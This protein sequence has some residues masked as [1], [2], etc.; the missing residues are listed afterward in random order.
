MKALEMHS[1][2]FRFLKKI[3]SKISSRKTQ[4]RKSNNFTDEDIEAFSELLTKPEGAG[5]GW[6]A[7]AKAKNPEGITKT[8]LEEIIRQEEFAE[9]SDRINK[10]GR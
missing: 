10:Q 1:Q 3:Q 4:G 9:A 2:L 8:E 7:E 5:R 6:V